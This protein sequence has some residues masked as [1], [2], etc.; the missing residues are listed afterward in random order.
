MRF[1]KLPELSKD[2]SEEEFFRKMKVCL[3]ERKTPIPGN[4]FTNIKRFEKELKQLPEW[5]SDLQAI[6]N[7]EGHAGNQD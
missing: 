4:P 6:Y 3:Q 5:Q 7:S 1:N 2:D